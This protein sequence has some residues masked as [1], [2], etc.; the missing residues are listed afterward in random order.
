MFILPLSCDGF[1]GCSVMDRYPTLV[2][3]GKLKAMRKRRYTFS[4]F[5]S[6]L[7]DRTAVRSGA[8]IDLLSFRLSVSQGSL[9]GD[10]LLAPP[11]P[12]DKITTGRP[13]LFN[14]GI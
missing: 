7:H 8:E 2:G 3:A 5:S 4:S 12:I 13:P 1:S 14:L 9:L 10:F 6:G 11:C